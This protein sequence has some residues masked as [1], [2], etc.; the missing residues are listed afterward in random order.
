MIDEIHNLIE[1]YMLWL[2]D[3]TV[4]REVSDEWV[5]ITTPHLDR[6]NDYL[7]IYVKN[8][9]GSLVLTDD[10]FIVGD[11]TQ[12]GCKLDS[13]KRQSLFRMTLAGFGVQECDGRLEVRATPENFPLRKHNLI[14]AM[15]AVDDLFYLAAPMV[16]SLFYEDVV[17]WL[18][19][20]DI[21]YTP[22]I[23][24]TG[25]SG[26]DHLFDFVIPKSR[27]EPERIIQTITRPSKDSAEATAFK[28]IDT[29]GV[30][31][32]ES[33]AYA[34]LNDQDRSVAPGVMEAL[35]S[36]E[37]TAVPWSERKSVQLELA[38]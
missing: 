31:P 25:K 6:H 12:S 23:K 29:K 32:P 1:A 5:E 36:Y 2:R 19:V 27:R 26:Y 11:L 3:K 20:S 24:F 38:G 18:E 33:K 4:L 37:I 35:E 14:Q 7:Q 10:G 22:K 8:E 17:D 15:L 21:R 28:W 13:P 30:R 16:A 34:I 9:A